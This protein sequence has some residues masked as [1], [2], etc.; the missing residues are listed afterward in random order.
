MANH[1]P[2]MWE[3]RVLFLGR[4]DPLEKEMATHSS[5]LAWRI[6]WTEEPGGIQSTGSHRVGCYWSHLAHTG[7]ELK[8]SDLTASSL[9]HLYLWLKKVS[10]SLNAIGKFLL[11]WPH[12][13][14]SGLWAWPSWNCH[15]RSWVCQACLSPRSSVWAPGLLQYRHHLWE[16]V[17]AVLNVIP[18]AIRPLQ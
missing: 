10:F 2:A 3:T 12:T 16:S 9:C 14:E 18:Q 1:L 6:P 13:E 7:W 17:I 15:H 11:I 4:E 5:I 8:P